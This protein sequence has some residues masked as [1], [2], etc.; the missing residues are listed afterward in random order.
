MIRT[1]LLVP[2][3]YCLSLSV[4]LVPVR[5]ACPRHMSGLLRDTSSEMHLLGN[6]LVGGKNAKVWKN[7]GIW[8]WKISKK[9][10]LEISRRGVQ[11]LAPESLC[12]PSYEGLKVHVSQNTIIDSIHWFWKISPLNQDFWSRYVSR[13]Q[14]VKYVWP[15]Q[16]PN[17]YASNIEYVSFT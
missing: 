10:E 17:R 2:G 12:S 3:P 6:C 1:L 16:E 11:F 8:R 15:G 4:L 9:I 13:Q 7:N 5:A 14:L